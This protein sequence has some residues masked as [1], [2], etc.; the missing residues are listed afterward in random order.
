MYFWY[1]FSFRSLIPSEVE[2]WEILGVVEVEGGK[3][4]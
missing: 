3:I 4:P 1:L 2:V